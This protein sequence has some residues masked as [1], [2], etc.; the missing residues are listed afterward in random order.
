MSFTCSEEP[1]RVKCTL[2]VG[3]EILLEELKQGAWSPT[4]S[5]T[6][7]EHGI[8]ANDLTQTGCPVNNWEFSI[9]G[10]G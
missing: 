4:I 10:H 2:Q 6:M 9:C 7:R 1:G 3:R 5:H 8:D